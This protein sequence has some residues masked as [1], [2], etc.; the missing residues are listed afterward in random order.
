MLWGLAWPGLAPLAWP[1]L[2]V[3][4]AS[5]LASGLAWPRVLAW[6]LK[7]AWPLGWPLQGFLASNFKISFFL[8]FLDSNWIFIDF[9]QNWIF[10]RNNHMKKYIWQDDRFFKL[11]YFNPCLITQKIPMTCMHSTAPT[12]RNRFS[13]Y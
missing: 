10:L 3:G 7:L 1:G 5:F 6:P 8:I 4:L 12:I 13:Q 2:G 11:N 9:F